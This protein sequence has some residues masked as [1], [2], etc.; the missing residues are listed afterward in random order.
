MFRNLAKLILDSL[1]AVP[2]WGGYRLVVNRLIAT[3][4]YRI[5][6][7]AVMWRRLTSRALPAVGLLKPLQSLAE[8]SAAERSAE[9]VGV[10]DRWSLHS[11]AQYSIRNRRQGKG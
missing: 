9:R 1:V 11:S 6:G 2:P 7:H 5:L 3:Y 10:L 4:P 8:S